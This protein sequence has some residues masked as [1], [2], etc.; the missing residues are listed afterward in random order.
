[1]ISA[2]LSA[3]ATIVQKV[4]LHR[5]DVR[6][7]ESDGVFRTAGTNDEVTVLSDLQRTALIVVRVN[8]SERHLCAMA[9]T[10]GLRVGV[11]AI[12][13]AAMRFS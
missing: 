7:A 11:T 12:N 2:V 3:L 1:M 13:T 9:G 10:A 6:G 5:H 8:K 4:L